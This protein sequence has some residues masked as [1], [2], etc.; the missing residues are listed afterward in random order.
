MA[1]RPQAMI[2]A[3]AAA[4]ANRALVTSATDPAE[5]ADRHQ[6]PVEQRNRLVSRPRRAGG[7]SAWTSD[8]LA[9]E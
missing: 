6:A 7:D 1:S 5:P 3:P 9:A 8:R 4:M 2:V